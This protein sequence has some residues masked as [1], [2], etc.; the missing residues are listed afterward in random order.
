[1][2]GRATVEDAN[3]A[4][5][6]LREGDLAFIDTPYSGVHY[7]RFYHVLETIAC[8]DSVDVSG[9]GRYPPPILR[10]RSRYSISSESLGAIN[11]LLKTIAAKGVKAV[12]TF[13]AHLCSN[14]LS[15]DSVREVAVKYFRIRETR[16]ASRFSTLGGNG[17]LHKGVPGRAARQHAK[18]LILL[19]QPR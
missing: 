18:E 19:L 7:S 14:G 11:G 4:A 8:G 16:V 1:L 15:G 9:V 17:G 3:E 12:L 2:R 10:P 13:P 5:K 6:R